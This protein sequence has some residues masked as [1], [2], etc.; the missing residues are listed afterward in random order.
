[1]VKEGTNCGF[2]LGLINQVRRTV[3]FPV[4][5]S[6]SAGHIAHFSAAGRVGRYEKVAAV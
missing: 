1:M 4:I 5:A 2:D 6:S 3:S